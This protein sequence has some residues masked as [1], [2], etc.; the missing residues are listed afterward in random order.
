MNF[1]WILTAIFSFCLFAAF[2]PMAIAK[3][4][5]ALLFLTRSTPNHPELWKKLLKE[6]HGKYNVYIHSKEPMEDAF[7]QQYRIN[8]IVPTSW[9]VHVKAWQALIQEAVKDADNV[10]FA[11][12]SE[13]CIPLYSLDYIYSEIT[14]DPR[15]HMVFAG[16]WWPQSDPRELHTIDL[17]YRYGNA[18][19]MVLNRKHA[20]FVASDRTFIRLIARHP[21]DQ[22][23]YF[24]SFF[25]LNGSLFD[26]LCC[27]SYTYV[28]WENAINDGASPYHFSEIN[29][30]NHGLIE[31][32]YAMG[33]LFARKFTPEYPW[34]QIWKMIRHR[35]K[36][37]ALKP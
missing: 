20:E 13:A 31:E 32:A 18:E 19:W 9:S 3:E 24:S 10:Y 17:K 35:T 37:K 30:F 2:H 16:P 5:I 15:T 22:E 27:H 29:A 34:E 28:N 11:F 7:F 14:S 25:A 23:S 26:D 8:K 33:A 6:A 1:R 4:K 36:L 12:L 21:H